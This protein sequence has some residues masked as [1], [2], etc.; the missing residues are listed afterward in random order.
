[1]TISE[2]KLAH[3]SGGQGVA[4]SN[5]TC[6]I[7]SSSFTSTVSREPI[8]VEHSVSTYR[9]AGHM[10]GRMN[11]ALPGDECRFQIGAAR[12][13]MPAEAALPRQSVAATNAGPVMAGCRRSQ[14]MPAGHQ[15][16]APTPRC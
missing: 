8:L 1:M 16:L 12:K 2:K 5:L 13:R 11:P 4:N 7:F 14:N 3:L 9:H 15:L 10:L 6:P